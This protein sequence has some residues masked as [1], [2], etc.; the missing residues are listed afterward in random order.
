M[1]TLPQSLLK[2]FYQ[3]LLNMR[4]QIAAGSDK[5]LRTLRPDCVEREK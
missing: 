4:M 2:K 5:R 1:W 3:V